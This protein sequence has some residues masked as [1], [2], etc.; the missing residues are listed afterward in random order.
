MTTRPDVEQYLNEH[1]P[2]LSTR[3]YANVADELMEHFDLARRT[4]RRY[5]SEWE[6]STQTQGEESEEEAPNDSTLFEVPDK[7]SVADPY[8]DH[9]YVHIP[10]RGLVAIPKET[11]RAMKRR[12]SNWDGSEKTIN[13]IC[14]EFGVS[15]SDFEK[16]KRSCGWTHDSSPYTDEELLDE[17]KDVGDLAEDLARIKERELYR[18]WQNEEQKRNA[19][20]AQKWRKFNATV[21]EPLYERIKATPVDNDSYDWK[22]ST[23][24]SFC[25]FPH[26]T[27]AHL[28]QKNADQSGFADNKRRWLD[29]IRTN[30]GR[31][32]QFGQPRK[33]VLPLGG[34]QAN[35]DGP[36]GETTAGTP[37]DNDLVGNEAV[38]RV[39]DAGVEAIELCRDVAPTEVRVVPG[40]HDW[41]T[42]V[43]YYWGLHGRYEGIDD[44]DV[45]G[46]AAK[47]QIDSYGE[48]LCCWTHGDQVK[49]GETKQNWNLS[50]YLLHQ[51]P[52]L[53]EEGQHYY[54]FL[55]HKHHVLEKDDG[56]HTLQGGSTAKTDQWHKVNGYE[57]SKACQTA[58]ILDDAG[59][60]V[61]RFTAYVS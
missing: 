27:D 38:F 4:L 11:Y 39:L 55:G 32:Q 2:D 41:Q 36:T 22:P 21:V 48:N 58:Y 33:I 3:S 54:V 28:D 37:Q 50:S 17:D 34:D 60:Q 61:A 7:Q 16:F 40:N 14:R 49:G 25:A 57:T 6:G 26:P 18:E 15:R 12:Y 20:D 59:G 52:H 5:V 46:G 8:G 23:L 29:A 9:H 43:A 42:C 53:I 13:E 1:T 35:I 47:W 10:G 30:L 31:I 44:V 56:V 19:E 24:D 45:T 51:A